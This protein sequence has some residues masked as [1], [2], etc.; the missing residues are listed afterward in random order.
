MDSMRKRLLML[1]LLGW[2]F[3]ATGGALAGVFR[4]APDRP[5]VL[6]LLIVFGPPVALAIA[7]ASSQAVQGLVQSFPLSWLIGIQ[8]FRIGGALFLPLAVQGRLPEQFALPAA[9]GDIAVGVTA[10][11]VALWLTS[12]TTR[13]K[14]AAVV[15]NLVGTADLLM[16]V[17]LGITSAPGPLRVFLHE[18]STEIMTLFPMVLF[19]TFLVP[20]ALLLHVAALSKLL[21]HQP[22]EDRPFRSLQP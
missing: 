2:L 12:G 6:L 21:G 17:G 13:G 11:L 19:P 5:P 3:L 15:W 1:G 18:P 4:P 10:P 9:Y 14:T 22:R 8:V 20:L 7:L 16:A